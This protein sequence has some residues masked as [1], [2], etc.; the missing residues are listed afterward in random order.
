MGGGG[1]SVQLFAFLQT[2]AIAAIV[3]ISVSAFCVA[4]QR[5]EREKNAFFIKNFLWLW[6]WKKVRKLES[7]KLV[8]E[9]FSI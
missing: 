1:I 7:L 9:K 5:R 4:F 8:G 6:F 3:R 2:T